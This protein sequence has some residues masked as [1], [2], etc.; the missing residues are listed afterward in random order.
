MAG[1]QTSRSVEVDETTETGK[2]SDLNR[3]NLQSK[4]TASKLE[5]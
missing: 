3:A 1:E 5:D 4:K 2:S